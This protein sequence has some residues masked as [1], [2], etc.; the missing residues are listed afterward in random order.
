MSLTDDLKNEDGVTVVNL[1]DVHSTVDLTP[2]TGAIASKKEPASHELVEGQY[3]EIA[4]ADTHIY[5]PGL[6]GQIERLSG[7]T[8]AD[9]DKVE[10]MWVMH[11]E[12][13]AHQAKLEFN[14][15]LAKAQAKMQAVIADKYNEHTKSRYGSLDAIHGQCKPIWTKEGFSVYS[16][17]GQSTLPDHILIT[18]EFMH[19]G[20]HT[21]TMSDDWPLDDKGIAGKTNKTRI[22]AKGSTMSYARRYNEL[23]FFDI[24]IVRDDD[25]NGAGGQN[26]E[27]SELAQQAITDICDTYTEKDVN[28][29]HQSWFAKLEGDAHGRIEI[30]KCKTSIIKQIR[31]QS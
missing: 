2:L 31:D 5:S 11:K 30:G 21:V 26:T 15:S 13:L 10:R 16:V 18:T 14:T 9:M 19:K 4:P 27:L 3:K 7:V 12:Q 17:P 20:G 6:L 25:G 23:S 1:D 8:D 24:S 22:H 28:T 29:K